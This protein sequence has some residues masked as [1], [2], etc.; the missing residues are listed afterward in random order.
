MCAPRANEWDT[1][2]LKG[3]CNVRA[4]PLCWI[5]VSDRD[6][7]DFN[8]LVWARLLSYSPQAHFRDLFWSSANKQTSACQPR[9]YSDCSG[10]C[11]TLPIDSST[12][13]LIGFLTASQILW[14]IALLFA[15][16]SNC[17]MCLLRQ[18][19]CFKRLPCVFKVTFTHSVVV[20]EYFST[21][22]I[23]A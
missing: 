23:E 5:T 14:L 6:K 4:P 19:G 13:F 22:H 16:R 3:C 7:E 1:L 12:Y 8:V 18:E 20:S 11:L 10:N 17:V 15:L 9:I 2:A 21:L